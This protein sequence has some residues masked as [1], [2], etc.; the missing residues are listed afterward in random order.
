MK[1]IQRLNQRLQIKDQS[2][3]ALLLTMFIMAGMIMVAMGGA[4]VV[5]LGIRA[6]GVQAQSTK[7][8]FAAESGAERL[9]WEIRQNGCQGGSPSCTASPS[10]STIIFN[11]TLSSGAIYDVYF[12]AYPPLTFQAIG[13]DSDTRRSVEVRM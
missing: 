5:L 10:D 7:A 12:T 3:S 8:Y 13:E 9:L 2:G 11:G 6:G 4:Y 1:F